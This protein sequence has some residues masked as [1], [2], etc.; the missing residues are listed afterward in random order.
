LISGPEILAREAQNVSHPVQ[1]AH[2]RSALQAFSTP[3]GF[4]IERFVRLSD[5][6]ASAP[7]FCRER[8]EYYLDDS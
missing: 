1:A 6:T 8:P 3:A 5:D 7:R 4:S 2:G